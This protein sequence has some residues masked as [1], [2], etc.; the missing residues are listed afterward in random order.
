M[1]KGKNSMAGIVVP[2]LS[3]VLALLIGA[4]IMVCLGA[5]PATAMKNLRSALLARS[6]IS[7]L[8]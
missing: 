7:A 1:R 4:I 8:P 5:N 3:I 6:R 2:L